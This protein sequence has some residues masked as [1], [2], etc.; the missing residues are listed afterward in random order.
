MKQGILLLIF[1]FSGWMASAQVENPAT[2]LTST[3][4]RC[5]CPT[6]AK[7]NHGTL[8][9]AF[10][11][12]RGYYSKSDIRFED[13]GQGKYDFT[14]YDVIGKDRPGFDQILNSNISIP[15][16]VFRIGYFFNKKKDLGIEINYDHAKYIAS[17]EQR[18]RIKGN[19]DGNYL[20]T[21]TVI[22]KPFIAFE[23]TNG[24]N[25]AILNLVKRKTLLHD[26]TNNHWLSV[27][28]KAGGGFVYPRTD[29]TLFGVRRDDKFHVAGYI[30]GVDVA[31]RYDF[32]HHFFI[33][34]EA[35]YTFVNYTDALLPFGGRAHHHFFAFEYILTAG[36]S[37][38]L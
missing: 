9:F 22:G 21:D 36:V 6:N 37:I 30:A 23:H 2:Q 4:E 10:G 26:K 13:Q 14:L 32:F 35:K 7:L 29:A 3:S 15:Q 25:F 8:Y 31:L 24:A 16:Y 34:N 20:D 1:C 28:G 5:N 17:D 12:N 38:N 33:E 18:V 27:L 11:Y 19:V